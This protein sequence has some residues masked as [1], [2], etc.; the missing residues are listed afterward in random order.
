MAYQKPSPADILDEYMAGQ[1]PRVEEN[2]QKFLEIY[3]QNIT[4]KGTDK[5]LNWLQSETSDFF[6]APA[7]TQYH[8]AYPGGLCEHSL[9]VYY[10]LKDYLARERVRETYG[11]SASEETIAIVGLLH[12]LCKVNLYT[13]S[14]RNV[15]DDET[16][17]WHKEPSY[18]YDDNLPYGHGEKSVYLI[19]GF[20]YLTREEAMAIRWH[21]GFT[22]DDNIN[23]IG[24]A[25]EM[26]PLA[27]AAHFADMEATYFVE[28]K[29]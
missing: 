19:R 7:S 15:K 17:E 6:T 2:K 26:F 9:N 18:R 23:T 14:L 13:L 20:T 8:G 1:R 5:L 16:G 11:I 3:T 27:V 4:R 21:M 25:F 29:K 12:D 22:A 10:C 28:G 24:K